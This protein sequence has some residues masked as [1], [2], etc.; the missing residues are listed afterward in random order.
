[1][2]DAPLTWLAD[3]FEAQCDGD[4]EHQAGITIETSDNP[5]WIVTI[6]LEGTAL[7]D[8]VFTPVAQGIPSE[9]DWINCGVREG[10]F[11]GTGGLPNLE[12]ILAVFREWANRP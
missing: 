9:G 7:K 8:A 6:D 10:R 4:W 1:M 11:V 2:N 3:W 5:G 12:T